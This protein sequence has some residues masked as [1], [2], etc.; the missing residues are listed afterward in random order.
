MAPT[1]RL[2]RS[3]L[4]PEAPVPRTSPAIVGR[5]VM[6]GKPRKL[7]AAASRV[8]VRRM[9]VVLTWRIPS[10]RSWPRVPE[11]FNGEGNRIQTRTRITTTKEPVLTTKHAPVPAQARRSP[12]ITGPMARERLK[13]ERG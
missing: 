13:L 10:R 7:A 8:S 9:G 4:Y 6:S 2:V 3:R 5:N 11:V 12:A 1:P